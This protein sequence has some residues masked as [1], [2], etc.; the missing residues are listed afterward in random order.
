[1]EP[2]R[3]TLPQDLWKGIERSLGREE[4]LRLLWSALVGPQLAGLTEVH[5][6]RGTTLVV[7]VADR[8]WQSPLHSME[9]MILEAVNRFAKPWQARSIDFIVEPRKSP[10]LEMSAPR[11]ANDALPASQI[12]LPT[13]LIGDQGLR[14]AFVRSAQK[15]FAQQQGRM[16]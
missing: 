6:I 4:A 14:E 3:A 1:M 2:A 16:A 8:E 15:Y 9:R 12:G 10:S 13:A 7:A 11:R 5:T